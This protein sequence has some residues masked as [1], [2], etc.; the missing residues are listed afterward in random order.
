MPD[1]IGNY[2]H[3][4]YANYIKYGLGTAQH[5]E[6]SEDPGMIFQ[7]QRKAIK[8][9][10][11]SIIARMNKERVR[12]EVE[13]RLNFFRNKKKIQVDLGWSDKEIEDLESSLQEIIAEK[14]GISSSDI[15]WDTLDFYGE[16]NLKKKSGSSLGLVGTKTDWIDFEAVKRRIDQLKKLMNATNEELSGYGIKDAE[17]LRE[18]LKSLME[19]YNDTVNE[20]GVGSSKMIE[21]YD[22]QLGRTNFVQVAK[23]NE[24]GFVDKLNKAWADAKGGIKSLIKGYLGEYYAAIVDGIARTK[25]IEEANNL[26]TDIR[27]DFDGVLKNLVGQQRSASILK[28]SNFIIT[29]DIGKGKINEQ[30]FF[31]DEGFTNFNGGKA[32]IRPVQDKVDLEITLDE[33]LGEG[34]SNIGHLSIKNYSLSHDLGLESGTGI[35]KLIQDYPKF[36]NHYLNITA[37]PSDQKDIASRRNYITEANIVLKLTMALKALVGGIWKVKDGNISRSQ[38]AEMFVVNGKDG[39][40]HVYFVDDIIELI[41]KDSGLIR[42]AGLENDKTWTTRWIGEMAY[43]DP[44]YSDA[45]RRI[46]HLLAQLQGFK[47]KVELEKGFGNLI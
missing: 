36:V 30:H 11:L 5:P 4:Q 15:N 38:T 43:H 24:N 27:N 29:G 41:L 21:R 28:A 39:Y 16:G 26:L 6:D 19:L 12:Q 31:L 3:Y 45:Y 46:N 9:E 32:R 47:Y 1:R 14:I 10:A 44:N 25:T 23:L 7:M 34:M 37:V 20:L 33:P 18:Q 13:S 17:K 8:Q 2:I 35:L 40:Y 22:F 42:I